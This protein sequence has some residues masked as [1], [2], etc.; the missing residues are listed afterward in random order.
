MS[1]LAHRKLAPLIAASPDLLVFP[2]Q[3][4]WDEA[5]RAW[6]LSVD[7]RPA[8]VALPEAVDDVVDAVDHARVTGL[9]VAVQATGHGAGSASLDGTLLVNTVWMSGVEVDVASRVARV[10]AGAVW[11]DVVEAAWA[12]IDPVIHGPSPMFEYDPGSWGP[13]Q[14]DRLVADIGGWNTPK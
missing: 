4:G 14:A 5:R 10:A 6:N 9:R 12:I 7:Q 8:A 2:G 13:P 1:R 3:P 11:Q